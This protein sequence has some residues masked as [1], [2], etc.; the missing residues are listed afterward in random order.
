MNCNVCG[1]DYLRCNCVSQ[2]PYCEQ[3]S[4]DNS[5][6]EEFPAECVIYHSYDDSPP[7][8]LT[9]LGI[10][11]GAS[12]EHI[13]EV[14]GQAVC[15]IHID[16]TPL[17]V[18]DTTTIDFTASGTKGHTLT[19]SVKR[20]STAGNIIQINSDG[21]YAAYSGKLRINATDPL[22]YLEDQIVGGSVQAFIQNTIQNDAGILEV[23]P[24]IDI[25]LLKTA[26][27]VKTLL[28]QDTNSIDLTL[29]EGL[30]TRT[31]VADSK[32]SAATGNTITI[33][34]DGLYSAGGGQAQNGLNN[35]VAPG[36]VELGG[37]ML[38]E[39]TITTTNP[40]IINPLY[41]AKTVPID[42]NTVPSNF[43][44]IIEYTGGG[45]TQSGSIG[46]DTANGGTLWFNLTGNTVLRSSIAG[47]CGIYGAVVKSG[48]G[49]ISGNII[50]A[51]N[52]ISYAADGGNVSD[53]ACVR[54]QQ[55]ID[56][57]ASFGGNFTGTVTNSYGIYID[58][59]DS[60]GGTVTN[61]YGIYCNASAFKTGGGAWSAISDERVKKDIISF[62]DGLSLIEQIR[63][64]KYKYNELAGAGTED[65]EYIGVIAQEIETV[66][67]YAVSVTK[68]KHFD[69]MREYDS[70]SLIYILINAVK[71]LSAKVKALEAQ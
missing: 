42:I 11:N 39:T 28:V 64:V 41:I 20:S 29:N 62:T 35:T 45:L 2:V 16:E 13:V 68:S 7:S 48:A 18:V 37:V 71:E 69:D 24:T 46:T 3:C 56:P 44:S 61:S 25:N 60:F 33:N 4:A 12:V 32:I 15:N 55:G 47:Y 53:I 40:A 66:V 19:G 70:S 59:P 10:S 23:I 5:C 9:C 17:T 52:F 65:K 21:L 57:P 36:F 54:I 34:N 30:T 31:L 43:S 51:S 50:S 22:D 6:A 63:P 58:A 38:H 8:A 14:I 27:D 49:N 1:Q 26:L 67:P